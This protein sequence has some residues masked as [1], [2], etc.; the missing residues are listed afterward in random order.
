MH[1]LTLS[2]AST[3]IETVFEVKLSQKKSLQIAPQAIVTTRILSPKASQSATK[4]APEVLLVL[5]ELVLELVHLVIADVL[6]VL[7]QHLFSG[8]QVLCVLRDAGA[9]ANLLEVFLLLHVVGPYD[10][11]ALRYPVGQCGGHSARDITLGAF[12]YAPE[13][14]AHHVFHLAKVLREYIVAPLHHVERIR[15]ETLHVLKRIEKAP[16]AFVTTFA[17]L[18]FRLRHLMGWKVSKFIL[19][20]FVTNYIKY[21]IH[22]FYMRTGRLRRS[23]PGDAKEEWN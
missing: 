1:S 8:I 13:A 22:A 2:K 21:D 5:H 14:V 6:S 20:L 7:A 17:S 12:R 19:N 10:T 23:R 4:G 18:R 9:V 11:F 3:L 16:T 15:K